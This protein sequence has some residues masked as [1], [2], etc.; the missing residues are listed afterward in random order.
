V[1]VPTN[2]P[3]DVAQL[4]ADYRRGREQLASVQRTLLAIAESVTSPDGLVTATVD[5]AGTLVALRIDDAAY[6]LRPA[7]LADV[8]LR[9]TRSAAVR[10]ADRARQALTPVLPPDTDPAA[11]LSGRAD[12]TDD[13]IA[14][15]TPPIGIP[16]AA[17]P[18]PTRP[19]RDDRDADDSYEHATWMNRGRS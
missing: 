19:P 13:D 16:V 9:T 10:A 11:L 6:R 2:H 14:A 18:R 7:E 17:R 15:P 1:A 5:S 8:I 3:D 4:M 12:L